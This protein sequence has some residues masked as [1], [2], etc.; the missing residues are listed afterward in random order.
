MDTLVLCFHRVADP[1]HG[2]RSRLAISPDEFAAALD[3]VGQTRDF[4]G[5][6]QVASASSIP[7]AVVT[8]DD[9][10]LDNLR[11]ALPILE[12]RGIPATFFLSTGFI[13]TDL[14]FPPDALDGLNEA[15]P[16]SLTDELGALLTDG[17]WQGLE[18]LVQSPTEQ[19]WRLLES[20]R[21]VVRESLLAEDPTRRPMTLLEVRELAASPVASLGPHTVSHRRLTGLSH[22]EA[23]GELED[24]VRWLAGHSLATVPFIAYPFGQVT[25]ISPSLSGEIRSRD[26]EPL[27]T[28][29][30]LMS[31]SAHSLVTRYG[32]PRLS[33]GPAE[34]A[35]WGTIL[36][37]LNFFRPFPKLWL[38]LL[39]MRRRIQS[40]RTGRHR[41]DE[42]RG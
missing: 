31:D 20:A 2:G 12:A 22:H 30:A 5:L 42:V 18:R 6:D 37:A 17:Y 4:V 8:F 10:Y 21:D 36:S 9:G 27:T 35:Q 33:V 40:L 16:G 25:D 23:V 11:V 34:I 15:P 3:R 13:D 41:V 39:G 24:S 38:F 7:R 32:V 26:H 28:I 14:L 19:Y 1:V 29:P